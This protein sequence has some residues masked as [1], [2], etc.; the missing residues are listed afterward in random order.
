[1]EQNDFNERINRHRKNRALAGIFIIAI[2]VVLFADKLGVIMPHW[3]VTWPMLLVVIGLYKGIKDGFQDVAWLVLIAVGGLF[4]WNDIIVGIDLKKFI[5]PIIIIAIGLLSILKAGNSRKW[6]RRERIWRERWGHPHPPAFGT[7]GPLP[8]EE[9]IMDGDDFVSVSSV[10]SG[11]K[12]TILSKS[13]K[14]GRISCVFGGVELDLSQADIQGTAT[15]SMEEV[16]G[17][18]KLII[19][20]NWT[21]RNNIDGVFHGVDDKRAFKGQNDADKILILQGSAVFAGV[22]IKSY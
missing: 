11:L 4:L 12:R 1:M 16:F 15:L 9:D 13:F 19:P 3:L 10:F 6:R 8:A 7:T 17:G 22:E 21:V 2:G 20:A 5:I 14:G 18:V